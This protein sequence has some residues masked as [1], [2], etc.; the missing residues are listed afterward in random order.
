M[1]DIN[2]PAHSCTRKKSR[3]KQSKNEKTN[4]HNDAYSPEHYYDDG[5]SAGA[6]TRSMRYRQRHGTR[7][8][9]NRTRATAQRSCKHRRNAWYRR[10]ELCGTSSK[11]DRQGFTMFSPWSSIASETTGGIL[12]SS[13]GRRHAQNIRANDTAMDNRRRPSTGAARHSSIYR[14]RKSE[15]IENDQISGAAI[16]CSSV[17]RSQRLDNLESE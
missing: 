3:I 9:R 2:R 10:L 7:R 11:C 13:G 16:V 14:T 8:Q 5:R 1:V 15:K 6:L 4:H 12:F 17:I